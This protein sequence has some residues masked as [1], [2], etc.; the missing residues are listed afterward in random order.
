MYRTG[1]DWFS[2]GAG[3]LYVLQVLFVPGQKRY[4]RANLASKK[5]RIESL[6]K[7]LEVRVR[8]RPVTSTCTC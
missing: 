3:V 5:D 6:E 7:R 1:V 8:V 4:T 2:A